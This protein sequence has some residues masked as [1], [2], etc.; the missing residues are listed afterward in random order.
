MCIREM[1]FIS[2]VILLYQIS[3]KM[4]SPRGMGKMTGE[5]INVAHCDF[6][7]SFLV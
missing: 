7:F 2:V 5:T 1:M 4:F 6:T 3:I